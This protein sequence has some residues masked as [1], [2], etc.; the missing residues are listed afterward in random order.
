MATGSTAAVRE[1]AAYS[2]RYV[3]PY[4]DVTYRYRLRWDDVVSF[5]NNSNR[6]S[7]HNPHEP[8]TGAA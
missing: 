7:L 4:Y 3:A 6:I 8:S 2:A 5:A 1:L